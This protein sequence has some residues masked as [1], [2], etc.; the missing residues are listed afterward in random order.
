M[1]EI[2]R[3]EVD[4]GS[5]EEMET[6][7]GIEE[8]ILPGTDEEIIMP[9]QDVSASPDIEEYGESSPVSEDVSS[10][11]EAGDDLSYLFEEG[12]DEYEDDWFDEVAEEAGAGN[13][14]LY[15]E[16]ADE[17]ADGGAEDPEEPYDAVVDGEEPYPSDEEED[18]AEE[19]PDSEDAEQADWRESTVSTQNF[20]ELYGD[21]IRAF[22]SGHISEDPIEEYDEEHPEEEGEE[23][24]KKKK[25]RKKHYFIRFLVVLGLIIAAVLFITSSYF[26]IKQIDVEGAKTL[27]KSEIIKLSGIS[28]GTNIFRLHTKDAEQELLSSSYISVAEV[29]RDFP[30]TVVIRVLERRESAAVKYGKKYLVIDPEGYVLRTAKK[31]PKLTL[32]SDM[33]IKEIKVGELLE[34]TDEKKFGQ[35]LKIISAMKDTQLYFKK[36]E[37]EKD[38]VK[39]YI[40]DKLV[41]VGTYENLLESI[42]NGN[43][44]QVARDLYSKK[45]KKGTVKIDGGKFISYDPAVE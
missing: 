40:Y 37:F 21:E 35:A 2:E 19:E 12:D 1:D 27:K 38:N 26:D 39:A 11:G 25:R 30:G 45:I 29:K 24:Q 10:A 36:I 31:L 33:K 20:E 9:E 17:D 4:T 34:V 32:L 15:S 44:E 5:P 42:K 14:E 43:L 22:L 41:C 7:T 13:D 6:Q 23:P 3:K 28:K 18:S 16:H 8:K